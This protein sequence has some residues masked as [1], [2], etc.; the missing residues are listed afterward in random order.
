MHM[1]Y[2]GIGMLASQFHNTRGMW[3]VAIFSP[4]GWGPASAVPPL[5]SSDFGAPLPPP[6]AHACCAPWRRRRRRQTELERGR[7]AQLAA[8]G[9]VTP[10]PPGSCR[11][12][13]RRPRV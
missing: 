11:L 9:Y 8:M 4:V 6:F 5:N 2:L 3:F 1:M 10:K 7:I 13:C 12:A